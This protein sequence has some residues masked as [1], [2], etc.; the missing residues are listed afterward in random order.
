MGLKEKAI[1]GNTNVTLM[2]PNACYY[3]AGKFLALWSLLM[4]FYQIN[5][6]LMGTTFSLSSS[7]MLIKEFSNLSTLISILMWLGTSHL[8]CLVI[9]RKKP[10]AV[11]MTHHLL[12]LAYYTCWCHR[13]FLDNTGLFKS[14]WC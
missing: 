5:S 7:S 11:D 6:T 8:P 14:E 13:A 10:K 3:F 12:F 9:S 1:I 2:L 4:L